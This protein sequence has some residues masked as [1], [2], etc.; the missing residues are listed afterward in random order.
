[1]KPVSYPVAYALASN[2]CYVPSLSKYVY[3]ITG[4]DNGVLHLP[5]EKIK[6]DATYIPAPF[7]TEVAEFLRRSYNVHVNAFI[8]QMDEEADYLCQ[9]MDCFQN[10]EVC[11][12]GG[13][14][15][16]DAA[17]ESGLLEGVSIQD[18]FDRNVPNN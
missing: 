17:L 15:S 1:M 5:E 16:F 3:E 13:F 11:L 9:V 18:I 6:S 7:Q 4:D 12:L 8:G 10:E 2:D 14:G